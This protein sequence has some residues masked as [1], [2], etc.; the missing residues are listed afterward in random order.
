MEMSLNSR[1]DRVHHKR[2]KTI[3]KLEELKTLEDVESFLDGTQ[4]VV[5]AVGS[6]S[7]ILING[8]KRL[9]K[10]SNRYRMHRVI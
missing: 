1:M 10:S 7:V 5:C 4:P 9:M 8:C 2:M 3:M 6:P